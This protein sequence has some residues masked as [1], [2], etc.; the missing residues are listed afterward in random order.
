[1]NRALSYILAK[2]P[3]ETDAA[4][5]PLI[6]HMLDIAACA[7]EIALREPESTRRR[8]G[9]VL[10]MSW[11]GARPWLLLL[12]ACHDLG[13]A[14][15]GFQC[16]WPDQ[17]PHIGLSLPRIPDTRVKHAYV[18]QIALPDILISMGWPEDL[19]ELVADA[20]GCHHG[21]RATPSA[22]D[23]L[24]GNIDAIGSD[25]WAQARRELVEALVDAL[26]VGEVPI[27]HSLTGPDF[28]FLAGLTSFT[29]WIGSDE[30]WF[31]F[32]TPN[33]C[34]DLSSWLAERRELARQALDDIGW[35]SR[36]ALSTEEKTFEEVFKL[37]PRPLQ[38]AVVEASGRMTKPGIILVEAPMGEGKTEAA[39]YA[40]LELQRRFGHRGLYIALPTR[41]TGNAMFARTRSFLAEQ[42]PR[43]RVDIQL[44][45]G[46][47]LLNDEFQRIRVRGICDSEPGGE[48]RAAAWFDRKKRALLTEY[49]VGTV[50]QALIT[51]LPVYHQ[52]VRLWGLANRVVVFDEIHAY[53][54]YTGTLL[55]HLMRWLLALDASVVLLTATLPPSFRRQLAQ[56]VGDSMPEIESPYPRVSVFLQGDKV[57]QRT[58]E[59]DPKRRQTIRVK[60]LSSDLKAM[61]ESLQEHIVKNGLG[62]ILVNTVQRAQ[63]MYCL[64]P[65]GEPIK[66]E[67]VLV[68]KRLLDGTEVYLFHARFPAAHRQGREECVLTTFG[69]EA[70]RNGRRILIATQVVEQS[71]DLDFDV[72]VSDLA[73]IDLLLQRAGR[74]WRHERSL[75]SRPLLHPTLII[76][77]LE[78]DEP[79]S[80]S[81][82]LYWGVIY[83]EDILLRS[84]S[85]LRTMRLKRFDGEMQPGIDL[86]GEIDK[87]VRDVY[88][89][90]VDVSPHLQARLN[91]AVKEGDGDNYSKRQLANHAIIGFPDDGSWKDGSRFSRYDEDDPTVHKTLKAITRLGDESI[92]LIPVMLED[93]FQPAAV[94]DFAQTKKWFQ[95]GIPTS[96]KGVVKKLK[97][98]G[99]PDGWVRSPLLRNCFPMM[100]DARGRWLEDESIRLDTELGLVFPKKEM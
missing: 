6:L 92:T 87:L 10:G 9:A 41:A 54:A 57:K 68:G 53:D 96:R 78:G 77:G 29:D 47:K 26:G 86:P 43:R 46:G 23:D 22:L 60:Y 70:V 44:L 69:K 27:K 1:M 24:E 3:N 79:P 7:D 90:R 25:D 82:P 18:S 13:K 16:R 48:V 51:I 85:V 91:E 32:G 66:H 34:N 62:L 11:E 56:I 30:D 2:P 80:F 97:T 93:G 49:G 55:M 40:H 81:E 74:L 94:P 64:Y 73:P 83:R 12:I 19:A 52:F 75:K 37:T 31:K 88:D 50:D 76:A 98:L 72:M 42:G 35:F 28:M 21:E 4:W 89:E 8:L 95:S 100:L 58:F 65:E 17:L 63:D 5:H 67:G 84:W 33:D 99:V 38:Q 61:R 20:V 45:H 14:C 59:A 39:Y 36:A 15:P 71:L